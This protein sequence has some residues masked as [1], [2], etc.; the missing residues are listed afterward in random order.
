MERDVDVPAHPGDHLADRE[1]DRPPGH[2]LVEPDAPSIEPIG[3]HATP[4]AM[5]APNVTSAKP[6][7]R[8]VP[9]AAC[10][11]CGD[12]TGGQAASGTRA[13]RAAV[14]PTSGAAEPA[15]SSMRAL[16]TPS[17]PVQR[18]PVSWFPGSSPI[19]NWAAPRRRFGVEV[20]III[21]MLYV[22]NDPIQLVWMVKQADRL[23]ASS[24]QPPVLPVLGPPP[25]AAA[26]ARG[27]LFLGLRL[28]P[29]A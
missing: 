14:S 19:P 21:T 28:S 13:G 25:T 4:P 22:R 20:T 16:I 17:R 11:P 9:R 2:C 5:I 12:G 10:C 7:S 1:P 29:S 3:P 18:R 24:A 15:R 23:N 8:R 27:A 26:R 6:V